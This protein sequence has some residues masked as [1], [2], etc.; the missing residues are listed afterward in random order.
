[1]QP[2]VE[3]AYA[4]MCPS[5]GCEVGMLI[6]VDETYAQ[7]D[8]VYGWS[9]DEMAQWSRTAPN[10]RGQAPA[11]ATVAAVGSARDVQLSYPSGGRVR[12][13]RWG[14]EGGLVEISCFCRGTGCDAIDGCELAAAPNDAMAADAPL[15][16]TNPPRTIEIPEIGTVQIP[17]GFVDAT[18]EQLQAMRP[19]EHRPPFAHESGFIPQAKHV[20]GMVSLTHQV[21]EVTGC[22]AKARSDDLRKLLGAEVT[23]AGDHWDV[24]YG[25]LARWARRRIWCDGDTRHTISCDCVGTPC[26]LARRTCTLHRPRAPR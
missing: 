21:M 6:G 7:P 9:V 16:G 15:L 5:G 12:K 23:A 13:R 3:I 18:P 1:M 10:G 8:H 14:R 22:D 4:M 19:V 24:V 20:T 26:A 25:D 17:P 11:N 2:G